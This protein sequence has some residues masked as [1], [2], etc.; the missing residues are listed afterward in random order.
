MTDIK[1]IALREAGLPAVLG[2][3]QMAGVAL[4]AVI[5]YGL[6]SGGV[7]PLTLAG[8][9][10]VWAYVAA[11]LVVLLLMRCLA[12]MVALHPV[13]S[14]FGAY[15]EAYL[16]SR[17]GIIVRTAY[18]IAVACIVGTEVVLLEP[19][20]GFWLAPLPG[21]CAVLILLIGLGA[22]N[23]MG[24]RASASFGLA[25]VVLKVGALFLLIALACYQALLPGDVAHSGTEPIGSG[26]WSD[27]QLS[28]LWQAFVVA[29]LGFIGIETMAVAAAETAAPARALRRYM[30][31]ATWSILVLTLIVVSASAWFQAHHVVQF[32][33]PPFVY[34]L[35]LTGLP[36]V[37]TAFN[38][39]ML[40]TVVSVLNSQIYAGS[41]QL[42][43]LARA[44]RAP[45][46][47]V[48]RRS[49]NVVGSVVCTIFLSILVYL[50]YGVFPT[51]V[52]IVATSVAATALLAVW[53][54]IFAS[55]IGFRR[56][57]GGVSWQ[58]MLGAGLVVIIA[59]S[60]FL[61]D[62][63]AMVLPIGIPFLFLI[64]LAEFLFGLFLRPEMKINEN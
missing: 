25:L 50:A 61:I 12:D 11:A 31:M 39:L 44:G 18:F 22:V 9:A 42:F 4:G 46:V 21:W 59:A 63:F 26:I 37:N 28:S 13:P 6:V 2:P 36:A 34:L 29:V 17:M 24:A 1:H 62:A 53:L 48:R 47:P 23:G 57:L 8:P 5:S 40:L 45:A 56:Q 16:G 33:V 3:N 51:Q 55:H 15:A 38:V 20:F 7:L 19:L 64:C 60:T 30:R 49:N 43:G 35:G 58:G 52:Y 41:R 32:N 14:A 54:A 10:A 27:M